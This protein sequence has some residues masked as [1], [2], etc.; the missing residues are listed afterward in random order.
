MIKLLVILLFIFINAAVDAALYKKK[1]YDSGAHWTRWIW[2]LAV[3]LLTDALFF[4]GFVH[5]DMDGTWSFQ[6]FKFLIALGLIFAAIFDYLLNLLRGLRIDHLGGGFTD[7]VWLRLGGVAEVVI[8][9]IFV[10][11]GCILIFLK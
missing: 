2:R 6:S 8:R 9:I 4:D 10:L 3:A 7:R 5:S 1:I 11:I